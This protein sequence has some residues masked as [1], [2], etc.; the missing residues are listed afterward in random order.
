[1]MKQAGIERVRMI[2]RKD[3]RMEAVA[4]AVVA[5]VDSVALVVVVVVVVFLVLVPS[6]VAVA[7]TESI[8][9]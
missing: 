4:V 3:S 6:L 5:L 2:M 7:C 8:P 1:M 9:V